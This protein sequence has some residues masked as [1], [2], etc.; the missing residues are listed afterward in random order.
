[1]RMYYPSFI[2]TTKESYLDL[3]GTLPSNLKA[4]DPPDYPV[5]LA[6]VE[7]D[8]NHRPLSVVEAGKNPVQHDDLGNREILWCSVHANESREFFEKARNLN[9]KNGFFRRYKNRYE[10]AKEMRDFI[11]RIIPLARLNN[12]ERPI[13]IGN[14]PL[15]RKMLSIRLSVQAEF[16]ETEQTFRNFFTNQ[17][18]AIYE[19][20]H[21]VSF[22][23][24]GLIKYTTDAERELAALYSILTPYSTLGIKRSSKAI[25]D[26]LN[27]IV[28]TPLA[29]ELID[30]DI[31]STDNN[32]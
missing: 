3:T 26:E 15:L 32:G 22:K 21:Q 8:D 28:N 7:Y 30:E 18:D 20:Q 17:F 11:R 27:R 24:T 25:V 1:M 9:R 16:D 29:W 6:L 10:F 2:A 23:S 13:A 19:S 5:V 4:L 14:M 12:A 31:Q